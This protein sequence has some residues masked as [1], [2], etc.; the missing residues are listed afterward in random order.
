MNETDPNVWP[1]Q[2]LAT[3]FLSWLLNPGGAPSLARLRR[4]VDGKTVLITGAS[5]GIGEACA[6]LFAKAGARVLLVARSREQLELIATSIRASGGRAEVYPT[7]LT[8]M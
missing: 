8:D 2:P 7:D 3:R 5:F 4:A 6:R 1:R